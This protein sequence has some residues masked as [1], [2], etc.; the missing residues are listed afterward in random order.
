MTDGRWARWTAGAGLLFV[1]FLV[2]SFFITNTPG[3][4]DSAAT[5]RSYYVNHNVEVKVS[6]LL[7]YLAVVV[8]V[9]FYVWLWRYFRSFSGTEV[10]AVGSLIGAVIFAISGV[11]SSG[12]YFAFTDHTKQLNPGALVALNQIE[13]DLTWPMTIVGIAIFYVAAGVIIYRA[14]ALPRWLAWVSWVLTVVA[15]VPPVSFFSLLATPI[16]VLIV[17]FLLW[18][19]SASS[20]SRT[21]ARSAAAPVGVS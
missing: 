3:S 11:L 13:N 20:A 16:W 9:W 7:V 17:S 14:R 15:L 21:D 18:R 19:K 10:P 5:I 1:V 4:G 6:A 2:A 12:I 8:G